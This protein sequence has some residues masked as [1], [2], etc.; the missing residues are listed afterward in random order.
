MGGSDDS[1]DSVDQT[2]DSFMHRQHKSFVLIS[3]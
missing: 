1:D 3:H 2:T